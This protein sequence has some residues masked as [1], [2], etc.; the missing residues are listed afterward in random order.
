MN[1]KI[2]KVYAHQIFDSRGVPT[3]EAFVMLDNGMTASASVPSGASKGAYEAHELRDNCEEYQGKGVLFACKSVNITLH[4][5]LKGKAID[6]QALIDGIILNADGTDNKSNLG[7]NATLAVSIACAKAAAKYNNMPLYRYIGGANARVIPIPMMNIIN[8]GAHS[9]NNL[10]IQEFMI[11][12][13]GFGSYTEAIA[14]GTNIYATLKRILSEKGLTTAVGDEGGFAP[15]LD[16]AEQALELICSAIEKAGYKAGHQV[17]IALDVASSEWAKNGDYYLPKQK[18]TKSSKELSEYYKSLIFKYPIISI[19]DPFSENDWDSFQ[20]FTK[21]EPSLQIVG[22]DLFV[23][24]PNR[25]K[26][27]IEK[28]CA[29]A[30]LIKPNQIGTLSETLEVIQMA[31]Q[32]GYKTIISHRSGETADSYIADI[33]VGV[34]ADYIKAG[35]PARGER[36][37]KYNRLLRIERGLYSNGIY[38]TVR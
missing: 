21:D 34:N 23:T 2:K 20:E 4:K 25:L 14:A 15:D 11:V 13:S 1:G 5:Y 24:N 17:F 18:V 3:V 7:A 26:T 38:G 29:N 6:D 19:E 31:K 12:P 36:I 8:G 28:G 35:A 30:I 32:N 27:G 10:D 9:D 22:D 16:N 33:S 37:A